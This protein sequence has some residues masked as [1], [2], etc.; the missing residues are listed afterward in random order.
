MAAFGGEESEP[1]PAACFEVRLFFLC[2]SHVTLAIHGAPNEHEDGWELIR[3]GSYV[4]EN[5]VMECV[6]LLLAC[7]VPERHFNSVFLDGLHLDSFCAFSSKQGSQPIPLSPIHGTHGAYKRSLS[8]AKQNSVEVLVCVY[9]DES[10]LFDFQYLRECVVIHVFT[11][12]WISA[13]E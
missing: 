3:V 6:E 11:C 2:S 7:H 8:C 9:Y 13:D 10:S 5:A 1:V 4:R 12:E